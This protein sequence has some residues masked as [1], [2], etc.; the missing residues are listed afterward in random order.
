MIKKIRCPY[1]GRSNVVKKGLRKLKKRSKQVYFCK[2]CCHRF[3]FGLGKKR[4]DIRII[5][6]AVSAYN[7]GYSY[8]EVCDIISRKHKANVGI[9]SIFRWVKEYDLGYSAIRSKVLRR[10]YPLIIGRIFKHSGLIYN[11]KFHKGK[12]EEF[13][14]FP[15][16]KRF[17]SGLRK[18]VEDKYFNSGERCSQIKKEASIN[19]KIFDNTKLNKVIGSALG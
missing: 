12:L 10:G 2:D 17:I 8:G 15:G 1:C 19:I 4:F 18:G 11:F 9:T 5:L 7:K 13:G 3:S 16:L 6:N 14:K